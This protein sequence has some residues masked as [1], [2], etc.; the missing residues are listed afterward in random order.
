MHILDLGTG[1]PISDDMTIM[2]LINSAVDMGEIDASI[3]E[4]DA[5]EVNEWVYMDGIYIPSL[6]SKR[7]KKLPPGFYSVGFDKGQYFAIPEDLQL[8]EVY[9]L[10]ND[11]CDKIHKEIDLFWNKADLYAEHNFT[12]KRGI[13]LTGLPGTGKTSMINILSKQVIENGGLVFHVSNANELSMLVAL[14]N[15]YLRQFE[16][17]TPI[18]VII[19]DIDNIVNQNEPLL[20]SFLD[21]ENQMNHVVVIGTSNRR[22]VL[23]DLL[24]RPSR[25]DWVV[26]IELPDYDTRNFYFKKKGIAEDQLDKYAKQTEGLS[27]AHLKEVFISTVLLGYTLEETIDKIQ[28]ISDNIKVFAGEKKVK[29]VGY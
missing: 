2:Q 12:H 22:H 24:L 4:S 26:E 15:D 20:L 17:D 5:P 7:C 29:K 14:V 6:N 8:D 13:L 25:F 18:I 3:F 9:K 21:G 23:N 10:P 28:D 1:Q 27:M 11:S 16:P 19:E